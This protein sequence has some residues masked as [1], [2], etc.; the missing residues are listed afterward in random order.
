MDV[1]KAVGWVCSSVY[2]EV[3]N[4]GIVMEYVEVDLK[5]L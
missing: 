4:L 1:G 2:A 3:E 5:V